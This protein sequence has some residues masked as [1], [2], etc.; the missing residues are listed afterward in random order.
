MQCI[1]PEQVAGAACRSENI[2]REIV[3]SAMDAIIAVEGNRRILLFNGAAEKMFRCQAEDAVGQTLERFIPELCRAAQSSDI[4]TFRSADCA[5][6][7]TS[8][9]IGVTGLRGD[10]EEF[11]IEASISMFKIEGRT[12]HILIMRDSSERRRAEKRFRR[13]IENAPNGIVMINAEGKTAAS[14]SGNP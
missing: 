2:L 11:P 13:L 3:E 6:L 12:F 7:P 10:G 5:S 1:E 9:A 8:G 4:Q 14:C